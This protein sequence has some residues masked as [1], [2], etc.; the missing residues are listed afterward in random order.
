MGSPVPDQKITPLRLLI[1]DIDYRPWVIPT[2]TQTDIHCLQF[3]AILLLRGCFL[4]IANSKDEPIFGNFI[5]IQI[6]SLKIVSLVSPV[7]DLRHN[8][9]D[10][11]CGPAMLSRLKSSGDPPEPLRR[12]NI[13]GPHG[14]R[15]ISGRSYF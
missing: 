7:F 11:P 1:C 12:D 15:L 8:Y 9:E 3:E 4:G 6:S 14:S 2:R 10:L 13:A 5:R